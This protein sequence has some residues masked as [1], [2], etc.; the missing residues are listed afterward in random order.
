VVPRGADNL[1]LRAARLAAEELG[2]PGA[3][4]L[5]RKRI[6][7]GAGLGGG[8]ADAAAALVGLARL[9]GAKLGP[10]GRLALAARLGSDVPFACLGGTALG[11]GRG[12]RLRAL[13]LKRPFRAAIAVPRWRISTAAAFRRID[14]G[15]YGLTGWKAKLRFAQALGRDEVTALQAV[16]LGNTFEFALGPRR[17]EIGSLR[18]RLAAAG[19]LTPRMTGSGSAVFGLFP[20]GVSAKRV[21]RRFEGSERLHVVSS[22]RSGLRVAV[23]L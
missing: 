8:S 20:A 23:V 7:A 12:E 10:E 14:A 5:L 4:F 21:V 18:D 16:R 15:K 11:L 13:R 6:P 22:T 2:L 1:V 17:A 3:R 19:L 9:Y